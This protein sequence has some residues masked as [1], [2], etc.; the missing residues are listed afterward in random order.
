MLIVR[1]QPSLAGKQELSSV[2]THIIII[3]GRILT[4][5]ENHVQSAGKDSARTTSVTVEV[6]YV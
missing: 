4:Q 6:L 3:T 1:T 5:L 2:T